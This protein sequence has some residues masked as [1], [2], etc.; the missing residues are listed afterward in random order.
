MSRVSDE[1]A[2]S[3][4]YPEHLCRAIHDGLD[5]HEFASAGDYVGKGCAA[6]LEGNIVHPSR[7]ELMGNI[8]DSVVNN[9]ILA[10]VTRR[11][12]LLKAPMIPTYVS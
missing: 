11:E 7:R 3:A 8:V 12:A 6:I 4:F 10:S 1:T 9:V 5:A 2:R